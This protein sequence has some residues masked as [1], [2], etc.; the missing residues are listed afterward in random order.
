MQRIAENVLHAVERVD[1][2]GRRVGVDEAMPVALVKKNMRAYHKM[3]T[4]HACSMD[5]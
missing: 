2:R 4:S 1:I 5:S 3:P